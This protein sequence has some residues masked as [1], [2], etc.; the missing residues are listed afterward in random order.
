MAQQCRN[1]MEENNFLLFLQGRKITS[2]VPLQAFRDLKGDHSTLEIK[3]ISVTKR[4]KRAGIHA[5]TV[6]ILKGSIELKVLP[7]DAR[8]NEEDVGQ[9]TAARGEKITLGCCVGSAWTPVTDPMLSPAL[10][11]TLAC[12]ESPKMTKSFWQHKLLC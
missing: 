9:V 10:L 11:Q 7:G 3:H 8:E 12:S 6:K 4:G 2:R 5:T 1:E